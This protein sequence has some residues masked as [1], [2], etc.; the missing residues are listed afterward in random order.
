MLSAK[1]ETSA[2]WDHGD[3]VPRAAEKHPQKAKGKN[4]NLLC[5]LKH[6]KP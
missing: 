1:L 4:P 5:F 3:P 6:P 2:M